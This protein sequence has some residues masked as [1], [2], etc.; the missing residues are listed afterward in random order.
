MNLQ[1]AKE[2]WIK[3]MKN[4]LAYKMNLLGMLSSLVG[5]LT[6][7]LAWSIL[8]NYVQ[9]PVEKSK[10]IPYFLLV[11]IFNYSFQ[12]KLARGISSSIK[13]GNIA[14]RMRIPLDMRMQWLMS[15]Y[16]S[17]L[18][19][20]IPETILVILA[21]IGM[22]ITIYNVAYAIIISLIGSIAII[23]TLMIVGMLAFWIEDSWG[24][25]N[26]TSAAVTF[27]TGGFIPIS[28]FPGPVKVLASLLPFKLI[29][30]TPA[31]IT[32]GVISPNLGDLILGI[33]W[34]VVLSILNQIVFTLGIKRV[35][36]HGV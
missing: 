6:V 26:A 35:S 34:A 2:L 15:F 12:W 16:G 33:I 24:I 25:I 9:F 22:N 19:Y 20:V 18:I 36:I 17:G 29:G 32:L 21:I 14:V 7:L 3:S 1:V 30:Y 11:N 27:F 13:R 28:M 10:I 31:M 5:L 8:G 23:Q 4:E